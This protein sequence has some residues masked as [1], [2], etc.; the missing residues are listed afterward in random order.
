MEFF[1]KAFYYTAKCPKETRGEKHK[2]NKYK[3]QK[4]MVHQFMYN[5]VKMYRIALLS[6]EFKS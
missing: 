6:S 2:I 3:E 1:T 5:E 4:N